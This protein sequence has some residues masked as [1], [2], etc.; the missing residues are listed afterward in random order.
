MPAEPWSQIGHARTG[1]T[2]VGATLTP[3]A[4]TR[5]RQGPG[6]RIDVSSRLVSSRARGLKTTS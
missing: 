6:A 5:A 4:L 2:D 3:V 1:G